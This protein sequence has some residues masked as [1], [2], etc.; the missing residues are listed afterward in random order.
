[1]VVRNGILALPSFAAAGPFAGRTG[2]F[3]GAD[4]LPDTGRAA[5]ATLYVALVTDY[6][7]DALG[8]TGDVVVEGPLAGNP[9]FPGLLAALRA[10]RGDVLLGEDGSGTIGGALA[11]LDGLHR[12]ATASAAVAPCHPD[13]LRGYASLWRA[14]AAAESF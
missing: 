1:V 5:L 11:L 8:A 9:F 6:A 10:E 14:E 12:G 7:L 13:G 4:D 2:A 3:L